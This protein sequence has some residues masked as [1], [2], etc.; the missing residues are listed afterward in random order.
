MWLPGTG[1]D[2]FIDYGWCYEISPK[3][4]AD[5]NATP[6][7]EAAAT[8]WDCQVI[9]V[10]FDVS[11]ED[12]AG[13]TFAIEDWHWSGEYATSNSNAWVY[14]DAADMVVDV[15]NDYTIDEAESGAFCDAD[16]DGKVTCA[17]PSCITSSGN[18]SGCS[19]EDF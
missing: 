5:A 14:R 3:T 1:M 4:N 2:P 12:N 18:G 17:M 19:D 7:V 6:P 15:N 16:E 8:K 10:D 13:T 9:K 11:T